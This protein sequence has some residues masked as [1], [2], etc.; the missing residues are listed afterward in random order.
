MLGSSTSSNLAKHCL[1]IDGVIALI[2]VC[3]H[4]ERKIE[5]HYIEHCEIN[6]DASPWHELSS[7]NVIGTP[8]SAAISSKT[9]LYFCLE[10]G[11]HKMLWSFQDAY[12]ADP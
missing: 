3:H 5:K 7:R 4:G 1:C 9:L 8:Y 12:K 11:M 10:N 2:I 6:T